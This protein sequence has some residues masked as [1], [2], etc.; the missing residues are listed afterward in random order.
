MEGLG[1][2]LLCDCVPSGMASWRCLV[3]GCMATPVAHTQAPYATVCDSSSPPPCLTSVKASG[4]MDSTLVL[5]STS[6]PFLQAKLKRFKPLSTLT[7]SGAELVLRVLYLLPITYSCSPCTSVMVQL[8][9]TN[10]AICVKADCEHE[11]RVLCQ[12]QLVTLHWGCIDS[13]D[14]S[15]YMEIWYRH[16]LG[17]TA[18]SA[19]AQEQSW[20]LITHRSSVMP[21]LWK[22]MPAQTRQSAPVLAFVNSSTIHMNAP[23]MCVAMLIL[24]AFGLQHR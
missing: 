7:L 10:A 8:T 12:L 21:N 22:L 18:S 20:F 1:P 5:I 3:R 6:T 24:M 19:A 14:C 15:H 17:Q 16:G 23:V 9:V 11:L 4:V 13:H 2:C